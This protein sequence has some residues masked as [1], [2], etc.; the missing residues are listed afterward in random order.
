[1]Q[2]DSKYSPEHLDLLATNPS[3]IPFAQ[4]VRRLA[5]SPQLEQKVL[6]EQSRLPGQQAD[7]NHKWGQLIVDEEKELATEVLLL[8]HRFTEQVF[9]E[10]SFRQ[11]ALTIIQN[12]YLFQNRKIFF[13]TNSHDSSERE[14]QEALQ[15]FSGNPDKSSLPIAKSFQHLILA[16][17]W[18]R[19]LNNL[20]S[21]DRHRKRF[22]DLQTVVEQLNTIRNIYMLLTGGLV[23]KL[24][25]RINTIYKESVTE[26][27]A[28]QIG[29]LGIA[30]AAYRYHQSSGVR[31]STYASNWIFKEIQRQSLQGRLIRLSSNIVEQYVKAAKNQDSNQLNQVIE[32]IKQATIT[33]E[34][35]MESDHKFPSLQQWSPYP[36]PVSQ[37]EAKEQSCSLRQAIDQ[38]L[39]T[40][41][42]DIIKRRYGLPPY[43]GQEQSTISISQE[44]RVTRGAIYQLE[45]TALKKLNRH[46]TTKLE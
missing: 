21:D 3:G 10:R 36:Q 24:A 1:M 33:G 32:K 11:A 26:E 25:T 23:R 9:Q 44:Y 13:G 42:G 35:F 40:K 43:E 22:L 15:L 4:R 38:L 30:R 6:E 19:I 28:I 31:F 29:S 16:R 41:S 37:L 39:S 2:V 12:I 27:D 17:V 46:F 18:N 20:D 8:R 5:L 45:Q 14:R 34:D 7:Q